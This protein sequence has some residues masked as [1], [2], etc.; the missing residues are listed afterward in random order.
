MLV[1]KVD[2]RL[3]AQHIT[4]HQHCRTRLI[5]TSKW[6]LLLTTLGVQVKQLVGCVCV[7]VRL[8]NTFRTRSHPEMVGDI[9]CDLELWPIKNSLCAFRAR[10]KTY[11]NTKNYTCTFTGSHLRVVT[12]LQTGKTTNY[13]GSRWNLENESFHTLDMTSTWHSC[14][15]L[16]EHFKTE[17]ENTLVQRS[18]SLLTS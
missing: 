12:G 1:D 16:C 6:H 17:I 8:V 11:T 9:A 3:P 5:N 10:V 14:F 15:T 7:S 13:L 2:Q 18:F 4:S